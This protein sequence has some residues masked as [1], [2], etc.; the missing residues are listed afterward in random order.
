MSDQILDTSVAKELFERSG[1][2]ISEWSRVNGF[3]A[4]LVYQVLDGQRKCRR[5]QSHQIAVA[6]GLKQGVV[7][8]IDE[9]S[10]QLTAATVSTNV[11]K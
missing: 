1:I 3:S 6:L 4:I 10:R 5:G 8:G 7:M 11:E 9:L 2:S